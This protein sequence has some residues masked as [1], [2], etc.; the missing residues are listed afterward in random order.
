MKLFCSFVQTSVWSYP[1][2]LPKSGTQLSIEVGVTWVGAINFLSPHEINAGQNI[3]TI[4]G[5][6]VVILTR[7]T[8]IQFDLHLPKFMK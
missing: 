4:A 8:S 7:V 1:H 3:S 5:G 2:A 6:A